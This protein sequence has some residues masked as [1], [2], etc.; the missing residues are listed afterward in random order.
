MLARNTDGAVTDPRVI[1]ILAALAGRAPSIAEE[2]SMRALAR[3]HASAGQQKIALRYLLELGGAGDLMFCGDERTT[4]FRLGSQALTQVLATIAGGA[5]LSFAG[6]S[7][8][9]EDDDGPG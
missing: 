3:G 5:W 1:A 7:E 4:S 6:P 8:E 2:H 9:D